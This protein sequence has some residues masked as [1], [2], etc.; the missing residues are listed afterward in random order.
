MRA[1]ANPANGFNCVLLHFSADPDGP[2][3]DAR[4][5]GMADEDYK[6]EHALDFTSFAG[7][8]VY[9][10]FSDKHVKETFFDPKFPVW[11]GWDFGYHRPAV[12]YA[13]VHGGFWLLGEV[14]GE[15]MTLDE[16]LNKLVR[17]YEYALFG[18]EKPK[19]HDAADPAGRQ[20][21]DKSEFTSFAILANNGIFPIARK[22]EIAEGLTIVRQRIADQSLAVHPRCRLL[23]EGFKGG[24][25]YPEPTSGTPEPLYPLKDGFYDHL[26]DALRYIA[27]NAYS[28]WKPRTPKKQDPYEDLPPRVADVLRRKNK[29][30][31]PDF[32]VY[33]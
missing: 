25:H 5:Q 1:W 11:R 28:V 9:A 31:D 19:F 27:V 33:G 32:G 23:I 20:V 4:R 21:S 29:H 6:R 17:P 10:A 16:F 24:Y 12:V 30:Y 7:K 3:E 18:N 2:D 26:H 13:Q 15:D 8:P 22:T 14:L